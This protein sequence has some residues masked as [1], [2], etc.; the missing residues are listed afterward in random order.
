MGFNMYMIPIRVCCLNDP[1]SA[2]IKLVLEIEIR[3]LPI[4]HLNRLLDAAQ[5]VFDHQGEQTRKSIPINQS[6]IVTPLVGDTGIS[7]YDN[8][9]QIHKPI[10]ITV[11]TDTDGIL[12]SQQL[13]FQSSGEFFNLLGEL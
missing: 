4:Q 13:L 10:C 6:D 5:H 8:S 7:F 2:L 1:D 12:I 3:F 9:L 11:D